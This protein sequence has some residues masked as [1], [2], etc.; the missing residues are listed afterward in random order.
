MGSAGVEVL[1]PVPAQDSGFGQAA[2]GVGLL[3]V[4]VAI[5]PCD[6]ERFDVLT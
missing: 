1:L 6:G 3:V 4:P 5:E 2:V